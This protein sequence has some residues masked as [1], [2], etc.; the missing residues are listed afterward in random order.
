MDKDESEFSLD[1]IKQHNIKMY[2]EWKY[3]SRHSSSHY[4]IQL[5]DW[6]H[7]LGALYPEKELHTPHLGSIGSPYTPHHTQAQ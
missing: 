4:W 2:G 7:I 5:H 3:C 6:L 1:L